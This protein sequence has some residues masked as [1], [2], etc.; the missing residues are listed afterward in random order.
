VKLPRNSRAQARV[1]KFIT[2]KDVEP[3]DLLFFR[4]D[5]Y[6][7]NRIGHV[8]MDIGGGR[9]LNTYKSPPGVTISTWRNSF[10]L[11]RHITTREIL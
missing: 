10:W 4:R 7:D 3:G 2:L 1:G 8:G 11:K 9:M 5:R 6:S